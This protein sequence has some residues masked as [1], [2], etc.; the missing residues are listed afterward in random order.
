MFAV[1][2]EMASMCFAISN[3]IAIKNIPSL[4]SRAVLTPL[5]SLVGLCFLHMCPFVSWTT[6]IWTPSSLNRCHRLVRAP[7]VLKLLALQFCRSSGRLLW[8]SISKSSLCVTPFL[9]PPYKI[10]QPFKTHKWW[11]MFHFVQ[12]HRLSSLT[13]SMGKLFHAFP[14]I[15]SRL[16]WSMVVKYCIVH[17]VAV[18]ASH[19]DIPPMQFWRPTV[20][21]TLATK[22]IFCFCSIAFINQMKGLAVTRR[23]RPL[24]LHARYPCPCHRPWD[25][26][27]SSCW[28]W[29]FHA[30]GTTKAQ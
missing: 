18:V 12:P 22:I 7:L 30:L 16:Q 4:S 13:P 5:P 25:L 20:C 28:R 10:P 14:P 8:Y 26:M 24:P 3:V 6:C 1:V 23:R 9:S 2:G 11:C 17:D 27:L 15:E 19:V 29:H 21:L